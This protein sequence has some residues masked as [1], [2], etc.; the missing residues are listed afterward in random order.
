[1]DSNDLETI[2]PKA[3]VLDSDSDNRNESVAK[4]WQFQKGVSANPGGRPKV[5]YSA[6]IA[7]LVLEKSQDK[8]QEALSRCLFAGL[9]RGDIKAFKVIAERAY[10]K[11]PQPVEH[12]GTDG[13]PIQIVFGVD[14]PPWLKHGD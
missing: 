10:G 8:L 13:G 7:R 12:G 6:R 2:E 1:M 4:P 11:L 3:V 5:D 9:K 14:A